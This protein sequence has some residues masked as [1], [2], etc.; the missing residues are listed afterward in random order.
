[1][2]QI[3]KEMKTIYPSKPIRNMK[4]WKAYI[5]WNNEQKFKK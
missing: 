5:K 4:I 2:V 1:M 3:R